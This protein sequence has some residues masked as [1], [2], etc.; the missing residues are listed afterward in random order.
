M[1]DPTCQLGEY[2]IEAPTALEAAMIAMDLYDCWH[3]EVELIPEPEPTPV[4]EVTEQPGEEEL[5]SPETKEEPEVEDSVLESNP[6]PESTKGS[7]PKIPRFKVKCICT[8]NSQKYRSE[9]SN[10]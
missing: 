5:L 6:A 8:V 9:T 2:E 4:P 7:E 3:V 10:E 1:Y